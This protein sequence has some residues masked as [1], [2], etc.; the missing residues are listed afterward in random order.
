MSINSEN[1][2]YKSIMKH[3]GCIW[4]N[5]FITIKSL[6]LDA[7]IASAEYWSTLQT[8]SNCPNNLWGKRGKDP[9]KAPKEVSIPSLRAIPRT[10]RSLS[11]LKVAVLKGLHVFITT[12]LTWSR[13]G[14]ELGFEAS[15]SFE[16][17]EG[18]GKNS[19]KKNVCPCKECWLFFSNILSSC[20]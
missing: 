12:Y 9:P 17:E 20:R 8:S 11:F 13:S 6:S 10:Q 15:A 19:M 14:M 18:L 5:I 2:I 3:E 4:T 16:R 1:M 7:E